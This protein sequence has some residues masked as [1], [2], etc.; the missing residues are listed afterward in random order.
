MK[1]GIVSDI[2]SNVVALKE[3]IKHFE[4]Q[5][6]EEFFFLGDFISDAF[7]TRETMD[8][9]YDFMES[10]TCHILRG[11]REEYMIN[12]RS[13][14]LK[15]NTD[16]IWNKS[17]CCGNL[18]FAYEQLN[19]NDI[20]FFESL[21]ITF[22][23]HKEGFPDIICCH[24]SPESTRELLQLDGVNTRDWLDKIDADYLICG[25]THYPGTIEHNG[26]RYI[27]NGSVG[28][29]IKDYG[30]AQCTII[31]SVCEAGKV[32]WKPSF[33]RI[34]FDLVKVTQDIKNGGM[35]DYAPWFVNSNLL[36]FLT[37]E[38]LSYDMLMLAMKLADERGKQ[39]SWP[40]IDEKCFEDAAK[41]MNIPD[42]RKIDI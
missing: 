19:D 18:L 1:I 33:Y 16:R 28:I 20:D 24:G 25:H 29:A 27:N 13:D 31:E 9:I 26:K 3:C 5:G 17:S 42:Y 23:Y 40:I 32:R 6:C 2:H 12:Q 34:P 22:R 35:I 36:T 39:N 14:R 4:E 8:F 41:Q 38:D 21:P 10:H 15:G 11:N 30:L 7:Y 37:G